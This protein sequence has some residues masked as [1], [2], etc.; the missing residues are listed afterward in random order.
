MAVLGNTS[1][2]RAAPDTFEESHDNSE[3]HEPQIGESTG[4]GSGYGEKLNVIKK[5]QPTSESAVKKED[6]SVS[7]KQ[8][9]IGREAGVLVEQENEEI[10]NSTAGRGIHRRRKYGK[11]RAHHVG[12]SQRKE[13][14]DLNEEHVDH[15]EEEKREEPEPFIRKKH[16]NHGRQVDKSG[17]ELSE[18]Q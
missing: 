18:N 10:K 4:E 15:G 11:P 13:H 3:Q 12:Y 1:F 6:S 17:P 9:S 2:V 5:S 7:K 16:G 8:P 14:K